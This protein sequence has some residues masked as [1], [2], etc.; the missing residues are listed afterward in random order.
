MFRVTAGAA[1][2][3]TTTNTFGQ[4]CVGDGIGNYGSNERCTVQV[5]A[6]GALTA[7]EFNTERCC[8][9]LNI[10]GTQ[11]NGTAG[12]QNVVVAENET[13]T[14]RSDFSVHRSGWVLCWATSTITPTTTLITPPTTTP[15]TT[16]TTTLATTKITTPT[17]PTTSQTTSQATS[18]TTTPTTTPTT[19]LTTTL[20]T[21][22]ITT[23]TTSQTTSQATSKTTTLTSTPTAGP[24]RGPSVTGAHP[25]VE[26]RFSGDVSTLTVEGLADFAASL[27]TLFDSTTAVS[28]DSDNVAVEIR[29]G[30]IVA[31]AF[32]L[33][34]S[35]VSAAELDSMV[36]Q[37]P[38]DTTVIMVDGVMYVMGSIAA[39]TA[40]STSFFDHLSQFATPYATPH[41]CMHA[42]CD[43]PMLVGC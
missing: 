17:T 27:R 24:T 3:Q 33:P 32:F 23:P 30:S 16:V 4:S 26:L 39:G 20:T 28:I 14:W 1:S 11:Y 12:P 40:T 15:T 31:T 8:D 36:A 18:Q 43:I 25:S 6:A 34:G 21:T 22:K 37:I 42:P 5:L 2:C 38:E 13:F 41:A 19:T 7:T 9:Y 29:P 10:S 35:G